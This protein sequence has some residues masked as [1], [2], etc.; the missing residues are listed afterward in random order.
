MKVIPLYRDKQGQRPG[1]RFSDGFERRAND[2]TRVVRDQAWDES[3]L[4]TIERDIALRVEEIESVRT[5]H[6][7]LRL[8]LVRAEAYVGTELRQI[9]QRTPTYDPQQFPEREKQHARLFQLAKERRRLAKAEAEE[10]R[11]LKAQLLSLL[12]RHAQIG[13]NGN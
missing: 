10:V 8:D 3:A 5:L 11:A 1:N 9:Q 2:I 12:H 13:P 6:S 7:G 4:G